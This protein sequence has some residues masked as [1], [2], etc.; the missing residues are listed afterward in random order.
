[1]PGRSGVRS[2]GRKSGHPQQADEI[3]SMNIATRAGVPTGDTRTDF[4]QKYRPWPPVDL[5]DRQ[6]PGRTIT[7]APVWCAVDLRDG[8]QSLIEPMGQERK[9]RMFDTLVGMGLKEIEVGFP[10]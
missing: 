1:M 6:W 4:A 8:N 2:T 5:R 9:L 3:R 10:S 7:A